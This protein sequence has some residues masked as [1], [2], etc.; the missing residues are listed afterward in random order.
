M[1]PN[2]KTSA[3]RQPWTGAVRR[4]HHFPAP[5]AKLLADRRLAAAVAICALLLVG[6]QQVGIAA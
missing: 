6:L 5:G 3:S 1:G 4:P 2:G